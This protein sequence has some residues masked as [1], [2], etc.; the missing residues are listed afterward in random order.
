MP[1]VWFLCACVSLSNHAGDCCDGGWGITRKL[2]SQCWI[3]FCVSR[4]ASVGP[5]VCGATQPHCSL[6]AAHDSSEGPFGGVEAGRGVFRRGVEGGV[7]WRRCGAQSQQRGLQGHGGHR[8][9]AIHVRC[10]VLHVCL[11]ERILSTWLQRVACVCGSVQPVLADINVTLLDTIATDVVHRSLSLR[12][13]NS[14]SPGAC[15]CEHDRAL[16]LLLA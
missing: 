11:C 2:R 10:S 14:A 9:G 3:L 5:G 15:S 7:A 16:L 13:P 6:K 1:S 4:R 12:E 8:Q